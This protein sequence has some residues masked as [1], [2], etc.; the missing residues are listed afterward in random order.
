MTRGSS[1]AR[2][3]VFEFR[4]TTARMCPAARCRIL[5][6]LLLQGARAHRC[7]YDSKVARRLDGEVKLGLTA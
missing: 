1:I 2:V 3:T 4:P 7:G 5:S 6:S